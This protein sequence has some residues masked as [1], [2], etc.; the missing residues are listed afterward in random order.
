MKGID[1]FFTLL[2]LGILVF[3]AAVGLAIRSPFPAVI[4]WDESTFIV[5]GNLRLTAFFQTK[6]HATLS[7]LSCFGGLAE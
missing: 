2:E 1:R 5:I 3:I 6:L 4:D 7:R